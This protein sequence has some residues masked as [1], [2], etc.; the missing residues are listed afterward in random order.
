MKIMFSK[1]TQRD[2]L[3]GKHSVVA[4]GDLSFELPESEKSARSLGIW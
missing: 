4:D 3:S 1:G 2:K